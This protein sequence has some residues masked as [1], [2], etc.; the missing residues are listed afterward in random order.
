M[1]YEVELSPKAD[2]RLSALDP[3]I[4][5][6]FLDCLDELATDPVAKSRPSYFPYAPGYQLYTCNFEA[7]G[8]KHFFAVLFR[9]S[10]DETTLLVHGFHYA[11]LGPT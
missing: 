6:R 4:Q 1:P 5:S 8:R 9:Y 10:A 11:D 3:V 7:N 2:E